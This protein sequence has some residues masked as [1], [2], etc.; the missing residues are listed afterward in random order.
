ML[1]GEGTKRIGTLPW[2][3]GKEAIFAMPGPGACRETGS[4]SLE[5]APLQGSV[6]HVDG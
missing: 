6:P 3:L 1:W 4:F 5:W 2:F